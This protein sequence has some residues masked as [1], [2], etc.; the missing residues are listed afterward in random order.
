MTGQRVVIAT[1]TKNLQDQ[2][3]TK[4]APTVAAHAPQGQSRSLKG[5]KQLPLSKSRQPDRR[6]NGQMSFDDGTDVPQRRRQPDAPDPAMVQRDPDRR[7]RR[8][9]RS[10]SISAP[11]ADCRSR[12]RSAWVACSV[13][14]ARTASPNSPRDRAGESSILIV[15]THLY[16]A[17]L[18][19]GSM[20]LPSR[21]SSWSSTKPTRP[22]TSSHHCSVRHS[23]RRGCVPSVRVARSLLGQRLSRTMRPAASTSPNDWR[24][25]SRSSSTT[26]S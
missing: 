25:R 2:L 7:P 19:S 17:H 6:R 23:R 11:G 21:T 14:R 22:S 15:N 13:P 12:P 18:A 9:D 20:L 26:T 3:A 5:Q 16:A 1:A 24:H 8:I 10:R 4:D